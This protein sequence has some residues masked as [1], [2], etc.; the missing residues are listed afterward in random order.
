[1]SDEGAI[2]YHVSR[3][4]HGKLDYIFLVRGQSEGQAMYA[5]VSV[6]HAELDDFVQ[7]LRADKV[8]LGSHN[9]PLMGGVGEP[10]LEVQAY[11]EEHY[12]FQHDKALPVKQEE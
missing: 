10:P 7:D 4:M 5:Y 11:M 12:Q 8:K 2:P 3:L 6:P 1:M 9:T